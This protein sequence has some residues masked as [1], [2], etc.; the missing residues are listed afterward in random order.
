MSN[1]HLHMP[2]LLC[3]LVA[4]AFA[5]LAPTVAGAQ[6][7]PAPP[8]AEP[9]PAAPIPEPPV[10]TT[11][12]PPATVP[13]AP[14][15][16]DV[17]VP[18]QSRP[19]SSVVE[20]DVEPS[21]VIYRRGEIGV[22]IGGLL[23]VHMAPY[24]GEDALID[25]DDPAAQEGFRLRRARFGIEAALPD[26][27]GF[28]L[29]IDPLQSEENTGSVSDAR[30]TWSPRTWLSVSAGA[31]KVPFTRGELTS[32]AN[33]STVERPLTVNLLVPER[34]L[35]ARIEGTVAGR[36][37]YVLGVMN[38]TE[39]YALGNRFSGLLGVARL[40]ADLAAG[41]LGVSIGAGGFFEDGAATNTVAGSA[42]LLVSMGFASLLLEG[43]CDRITPDDSPTTSPEVTDEVTRCGGYA[44]ANYR[45]ALR[46]GYVLAPV[47]R[48][49]WLD[50]NTG[51]EDAGD[52]WL[53]SAG[54]NLAI[55]HNLRTQ[56]FYLGRF[57]RESAERA[58]DTVIFAVQG[59][60]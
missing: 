50:D 12:E 2:R 41:P 40:Q 14:T 33:L 47:V 54:A 15:S 26:H 58:N 7:P 4:A 25:N 57:E 18:G 46:G 36:A 52:A 34:R 16:A 5:T 29:V 56:L 10:L 45:A 51:V 35:G 23:Q 30:V 21:V 19:D 39:G 43:I 53:L 1:M 24:V 42:D 59:R 48:V 22:S 11:A 28:L 3:G 55:N 38:A 8:A 6:E 17:P 27:V 44:E 37:R 32:S 9:A 31:D 49:E 60:L 13:V 20:D